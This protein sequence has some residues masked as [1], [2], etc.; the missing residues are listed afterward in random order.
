MFMPPRVGLLHWIPLLGSLMGALLLLGGCSKTFTSSYVLRQPQ[1]AGDALHTDGFYYRYQTTDEAIVMDILL[2]WPDGT[3]GGFAWRRW[4]SLDPRDPDVV[5]SDMVRQFARYLEVASPDPQ[6]EG[7][8]AW[9]AF[10]VDRDSLMIQQVVRHAYGNRI[11]YTTRTKYG[12]VE[13]DSTFTLARVVTDIPQGDT[14][15]YWLKREERQIQHTYRFHPL[16][17]M[18]PSNNWLKQRF[19]ALQHS[20]AS[21]SGSVPSLNAII[22]HRSPVCV[23]PEPLPEPDLSAHR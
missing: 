21:E 3:A 22:A 23:H 16:D 12:T 11:H 9:G 5:V 7:P 20:P 14:P 17:T 6:R 8:P 2:L 1:P 10:L 13:N 19:S 15:I 4:R 18:P